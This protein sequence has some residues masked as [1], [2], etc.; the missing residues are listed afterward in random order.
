MLLMEKFALQL[1][2]GELRLEQNK[3]KEQEKTSNFAN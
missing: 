3:R 2:K 1:K